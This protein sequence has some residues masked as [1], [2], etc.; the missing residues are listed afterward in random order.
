MQSNTEHLPWYKEKWVWLMI[1]IPATSVVVG[2]LLVTV[3]VS[4]RDTLVKDDYYKEG[5]MINQELKKDQRAADLHL[6]ADLKI[7]DQEILLNLVTNES[8][9]SPPMVNLL[10]IHPTLADSDTELMIVRNGD[11]YFGQLPHPVEG[12]RY[13]HLQDDQST[14]R[15][16]GEARFPAS[17][18][19]RLEPAVPHD[20]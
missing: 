20:G 13:I 5:R 3:A 18:A 1:G 16:K 4:G 19:I 12:R 15:L 6:L 17:Y 11:H 9:A 7:E 10:L 8:F 2:L 14:W